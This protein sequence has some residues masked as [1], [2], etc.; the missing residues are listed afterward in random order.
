MTYE[1]TPEEQQ[2]IAYSDELRNMLP[3]QPGSEEYH[4]YHDIM[5][6]MLGQANRWGQALAAR[7]VREWADDFGDTPTQQTIKS[8]MYEAA[9]R[10]IMEE[11]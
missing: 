10:I 2:F 6:A 3:W 7:K 5:A 1:L 4:R 9:D 11:E 8:I